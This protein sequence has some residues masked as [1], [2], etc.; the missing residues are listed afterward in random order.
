MGWIRGGR[1]AA[2]PAALLSGCVVCCGE[3]KDVKLEGDGGGGEQW[4]TADMHSVKQAGTSMLLRQSLRER[5]GIQQISHTFYQHRLSL[6]EILN[7]PFQILEGYEFNRLVRINE[8]N[9]S[10]DAL[11]PPTSL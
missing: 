10:L 9:H 5:T 8:L 4:T 11:L 6:P 3:S 7:F 1:G 2:G